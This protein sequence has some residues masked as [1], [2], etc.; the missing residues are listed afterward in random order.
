MKENI[1]KMYEKI[2]PRGSN[3]AF[4][5]AVIEKAA[6]NKRSPAKIFAPVAAVCALAVVAGAAM[7]YVNTRDGEPG[8]ATE[9]TSETA[10]TPD[11]AISVGP[12]FVAFDIRGMLEDCGV[13]NADALLKSVV[14][15]YHEIVKTG[16]DDVD[17]GV[18]GM[19]ADGRGGFLIMLKITEMNNFTFKED[20]QYYFGENKFGDGG[21]KAGSEL[22]F[23]KKSGGSNTDIF[24]AAL[25]FD[26]N[27]VGKNAFNIELSD[28]CGGDG[29]ISGRVSIKIDILGYPECPFYSGYDE[30]H[31]SIAV[32]PLAVYSELPADWAAAE[33]YTREKTSP[34][35][36]APADIY[37]QYVND[38]KTAAIALNIA[39]NKGT[40][41]CAIDAG[42]VA[43]VYFGGG[44]RIY[45][46]EEYMRLESFREIKRTPA[47]NAVSSP[48]I[49]RVILD[50]FR[51]GEKREGYTIQVRAD[52]MRLDNE[53][54]YRGDMFL[55]LLKDYE[56]VDEDIF[57]T[58]DANQTGFP[59][60]PNDSHAD[61]YKMKQNGT[62]HIFIMT[63]QRVSESGFIS[64]FYTI[65]DGKLAM[66]TQE[67]DPDGVDQMLSGIIAR[68]VAEEY[69]VNEDDCT[70]IYMENRIRFDFEKM[71]AVHY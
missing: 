45:M 67:E 71:T 19:V 66:F 52:V 65:K 14:V 17:I 50:E 35:P 70:L 20:E 59:I 12:S 10:V 18:G 28:I 22:T 27:S 51:L 39:L 29:T 41:F 24:A 56:V 21:N 9:E 26:E 36:F 3:A 34:F 57:H 69:I 8:N 43:G 1:R 63:K 46:N 47:E 4:A 48:Y 38:A 7:A 68:G 5:N 61:V 31:G 64:S 49:Y 42:N 6:R 53:E 60:D 54:L 16:F 62:E 55:V 58:R 23:T 2:E 44:G 15:P 13:L 30:R 33:I 11:W 32:T 40:A 25:Y 37:W